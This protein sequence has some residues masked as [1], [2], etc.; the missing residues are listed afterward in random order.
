MHASGRAG[1]CLCAVCDCVEVTCRVWGDGRCVGRDDG[2]AEAVTPAQ[3]RRAHGVSVSADPRTVRGRGGTGRP[4]L[5]EQ[6]RR[7]VRAR[8]RR[9]RGQEQRRPTTHTARRHAAARLL[10]SVHQLA[11]QPQV[12]PATVRRHFQVG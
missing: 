5:L 2:A 6:H 10:G 3:R 9:C 7:R 1:W 12:I 8:R 11:A 4:G